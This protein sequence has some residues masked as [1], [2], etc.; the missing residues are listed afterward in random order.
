MILDNLDE[1][2]KN[3]AENVMVIQKQRVVK[4]Y[5]VRTYTCASISHRV[6]SESLE[7]QAPELMRLD[8]AHRTQVVVDILL[9]CFLLRQVQRNQNLH[10]KNSLIKFNLN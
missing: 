7:A 5:A 9:M 4:D 8:E 1:R 2:R 3:I 6:Q 10:S